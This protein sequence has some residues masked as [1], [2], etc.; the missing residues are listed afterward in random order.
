[1]EAIITCRGANMS[2]ELQERTEHALRRMRSVDL[3]YMPVYPGGQKAFDKDCQILA[4]AYLSEHKEDDDAPITSEFLMECGF[5]RSRNMAD[6]AFTHP[7]SAL[8]VE[9]NLDGKSCCVF[10][11]VDHIGRV[12]TRGDVRRLCQSLGIKLE[13]RT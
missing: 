10:V 7:D 6:D 13:V 1:M 3:S 12:V 5:C 11:K 2:D 4:A 9:E 8:L